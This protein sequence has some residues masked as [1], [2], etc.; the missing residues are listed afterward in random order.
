MPNSPGRS[1][2][3]DTAAGRLLRRF[4]APP[5]FPHDEQRTRRAYILHAAVWAFMISGVVAVI[6]GAIAGELPAPVLVAAGVFLL[7]CMLADHSIRR[8][9]VDVSALVLLACGW[10]VV[11]TILVL[12]GTIRAPVMGYYLLL[13]NL[14]GMMFGLRAMVGMIAVCSAS[15][16]ALIAAQN[17]GWLVA[18]DYSVHFIQWASTTTLFAC[19]G[20]LTFGAVHLVQGLLD[21]AEREIVERRAIEAALTRKNAEL[22]AALEQ[23]KTLTGLLPLCGWCK[24][25]REDD[26]YWNEIE[27]YVSARTDATFTHGI[28][29]DCRREHFP[30]VGAKGVGGAGE[31]PAYEAGPAPGEAPDG[32]ATG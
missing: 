9:Q 28:C 13:V 5:V 2:L 1:V 27:T 3:L 22:Q 30:G 32:S 12:F 21:R 11:T 23:V 29:P 31:E 8:G 10:A 14:A 6:L 17:A 25:V 15:V 16:A 19:V 20:G 26:G 24:K 18:P 4:V 7:V